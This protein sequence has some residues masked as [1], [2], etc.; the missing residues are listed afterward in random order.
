MSSIDDDDYD[1]KQI[2][3]WESSSPSKAT[4]I[5]KQQFI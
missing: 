2:S 3:N 5:N 1:D 4:K